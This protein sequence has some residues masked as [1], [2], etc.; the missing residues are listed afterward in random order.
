[1]VIN[2]VTL[3]D[4]LDYYAEKQSDKLLYTFL[5]NGKEVDHITYY[6]FQQKAKAFAALLQLRKAKGERALLLY[7]QGINYLIALYGCF[8]AGVIAVPAYLPNINRIEHTLSR[9]KA[10]IADCQAKFILAE[11]GIA[12]YIK[13]LSS[14]IFDQ[15]K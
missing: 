5:E 8:Y 3:I 1:M 6:Q 11:H 13:K 14:E 4:A 2:F 12:E 9:L 15:E 7:P 10:V